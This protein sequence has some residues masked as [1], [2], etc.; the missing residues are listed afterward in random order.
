MGGPRARIGWGAVPALLAAGLAAGAAWGDS[1]EARPL[2]PW[3]RVLLYE[4]GGPVRVAGARLRPAR[5]GLERNGRAAGSRIAVPGPADVQGTRYRGRILVERTGAGLRV[6][7]EVPVERYVEG[8]LLR[9]VYPSWGDSVLR[10]QAVV[11]R[12]YALH[13]K[14]LSPDP[15]YH[16][17]AGPE[18]QVYGGLD[19][20]APVARNAVSATRGEVLIWQGEPILAAYHSA[21]G[22]RTAS[23]EEVWGRPLPYLV[24]VPVEGEENSPRT[25]WRIP[26]PAATLGRALGSLGF[27]TGR[28]REVRVLDRSPSGRVAEAEV[29]GG[30]GRVRVDGRV[31]RRAAGGLPSTLFEV[32]RDGD[33]FLFIGS[34]HGHGVGMSQWGAQAMAERGASYR[35]ILAR[36]YPGARLRPDWGMGDEG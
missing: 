27:R 6:I 24:S 25:Y 18:S 23:S 21:S 12:T 7:N 33:G 15:A 10:A 34:G 5:G 3:L 32:R 11:A 19:A 35:E 31:L 2:E 14:R 20:E 22:G 16:L 4:G 9:E 26:V 36:F 29:R 8:I 13:R 28:V 17:T 1:L 30:S